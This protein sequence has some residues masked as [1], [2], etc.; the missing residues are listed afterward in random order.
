MRIRTPFQLQK[1]FNLLWLMCILSVV[2]CSKAPTPITP[3]LPGS[4]ASIPAADIT[5]STPLLT[6]TS[7][8]TFM[9]QLASTITPS[10][11]S[12]ITITPT[13]GPT[14]TLDERNARLI[15]LLETNG[16]CEL[17]C[18]W[19]I[20]PGETEWEEAF[21][22]LFPLGQPG[23]E[24][25]RGGNVIYSFEYQNYQNGFTIAVGMLVVN[26]IVDMAHEQPLVDGSSAYFEQFYEQFSLQSLLAANGI[27]S[28]VWVILGTSENYWP[29]IT[30]FTMWLFYDE[31]G[32]LIMYYDF[33]DRA[34]TNYRV[35]P[36]QPHFEML[37]PF[38][39]SFWTQSPG[40]ERALEVA[41]TVY[42]GKIPDYQLLQ[43]AAGLEVDEFY[44]LIISGEPDA[45]FE[46]P[47][48]IWP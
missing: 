8:P 25:P 38:Q 10:P 23:F 18:I 13:L 37:A 11:R 44:D 2:G 15:E 9:L 34:D 26:G 30:L 33:A 29:D 19:G 1:A 16:G 41:Y 12:T 45:C 35:C 40:N 28:R 36:N 3:S 21:Q 46:T 39:F 24:I 48:D 32:I 43:D 31:D 17:P 4:A 47:R 20:M 14:F 27:P 22:I 42:G 7:T 5:V 6:H